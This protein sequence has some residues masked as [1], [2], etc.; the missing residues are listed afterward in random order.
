MIIEVNCFLMVGY[1]L[2]GIPAVVYSSNNGCL[3][4]LMLRLKSSNISLESI[5]PVSWILAMSLAIRVLTTAYGFITPVM[6]GDVSGM[7]AI[8]VNA[9]IASL[10]Y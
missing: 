9:F 8:C 4:A 5:R 1:L 3:G 7:F 10:Y 2:G 6:G